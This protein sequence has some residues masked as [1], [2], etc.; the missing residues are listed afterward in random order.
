[1]ITATAFA[2]AVVAKVLLFTPYLVG[3]R[4]LYF[5]SQI[6]GS[7]IGIDA[8]HTLDHFARAVLEGITFSLKDSQALLDPKRELKRLV[9]VGGGAKNA[10]WLQMQADIFNMPVTTLEV[11]QGPGL[12]AA[13]LAAT[14]LG[15]YADLDECVDDFVAY[16]NTIMPI[17]ENV[18]KYQRI[19]EVYRKIYPQTRALCGEK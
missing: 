2:I 15:W 18:D 6:R 17:P 8:R 19:Y 5:D 11:E 16:G 7:F 3:E 4:T 1:M 12:G 10:V 14:G 13:M 9:S